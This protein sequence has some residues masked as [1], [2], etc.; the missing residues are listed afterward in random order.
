MRFVLE[1]VCDF[2]F[3]AMWATMTWAVH[4]WLGRIL[5]LHGLPCYTSYVI[6]GLLDVSTLIKLLKLRFGKRRSRK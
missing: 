2:S 4:E 5:P 1:V 3:L 6:E